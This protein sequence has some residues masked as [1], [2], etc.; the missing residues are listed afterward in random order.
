MR[1]KEGDGDVTS[2]FRLSRKLWQAVHD[3]AKRKEWD[4]GHVIR[5]ILT[6]FFK[7]KGEKDE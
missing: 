4:H 7:L 3:Y 2:T 6:E 5:K 1:I